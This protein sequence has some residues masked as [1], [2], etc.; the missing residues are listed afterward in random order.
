MFY[1]KSFGILHSPHYYSEQVSVSFDT[2]RFD[3]ESKYKILV[4]IEPPEVTN[5]VRQIIDNQHHFDLIL[6]WNKDILDSCPNAK[7]FIFGTCWID[8]DR[9]TPDK[10]NE[11]SFITSN[12]TFAPGHQLRHQ[13]HSYLNQFETIGDFS[14]RNILTPPRIDS[15]NVLFENAKFSIVIENAYRENWLTEKIVDCFYTQTVPIYKGCPNIGDFFNEQGV[16][17]FNTLDEL[18]SIL[19]SLT[20]EKYDSLSDILLENKN[21]TIQCIELHD[22]IK[23]EIDELIKIKTT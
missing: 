3:S 11:I 4:Q 14:I 9:F 13:V 1:A 22:R 19:H 7:R 6:A 21:K 15:K 23:G 2:V 8:F 12:K 10:K 5:I 18:K 20:P 16:I 17:T